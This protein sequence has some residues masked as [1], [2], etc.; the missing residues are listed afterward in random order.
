MYSNFTGFFFSGDW[1][2]LLLV[3]FCLVWFNFASV[4][5]YLRKIKV[6]KVDDGSWC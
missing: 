1:V 4:T 5:K 2:L 6:G 3:C